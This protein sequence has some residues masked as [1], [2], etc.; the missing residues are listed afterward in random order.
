[1]R[2]KKTSETTPTMASIVDGYST[3][4]QDGY[5]CNYIN[6]LIKHTTITGTTDSSGFVSST[7]STSNVLV[8]N[9]IFNSGSS[10]LASMIIPYIDSGTWTFKILHYDMQPKS[11][12]SVSIEVYYI[13]I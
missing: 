3:S 10:V 9:A 13:D 4:T 8:L 6:G 12:T 1:M 11:N 5:S 7:L 2:I